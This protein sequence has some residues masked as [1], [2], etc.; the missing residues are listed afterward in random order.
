MRSR[1]TDLV[2]ARLLEPRLN[3]LCGVQHVMATLAIETSSLQAMD[4]PNLRSTMTH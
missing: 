1:G 3:W 2:D 4:A